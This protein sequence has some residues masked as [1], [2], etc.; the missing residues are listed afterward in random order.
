MDEVGVEEDEDEDGNSHDLTPPRF[1]FSFFSL[2]DFEFSDP[3]LSDNNDE[4]DDRCC[5]A[6]SSSKNEYEASIDEDA[7]VS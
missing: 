5:A 3:M 7:A 6:S 4:V 2:L 1:F